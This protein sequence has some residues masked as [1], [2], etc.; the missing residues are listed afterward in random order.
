MFALRRESTLEHVAL[1]RFQYGDLDRQ[2]LRNFF[3]PRLAALSVSKT[4]IA[5]R[6]ALID[7]I[8]NSSDYRF[9]RVNEDLVSTES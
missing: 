6:C 4:G 2:F 5:E 1:R 8:L 9:S 3:L 7:E